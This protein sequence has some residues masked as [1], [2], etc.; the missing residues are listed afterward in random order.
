MP[1][2]RFLFSQA[3]Q[4]AAANP[5]VRAK[6]AEVVEQKVLPTARTAAKTAGERARTVRDELRDISDE[7]SPLEDP[8]GFVRRVK[9]RFVDLDD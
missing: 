6:A 2:L 7:V 3:V 4:R 8:A 1:L 5:E 9:G